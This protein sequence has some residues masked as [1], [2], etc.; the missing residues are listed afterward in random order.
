ML[1][2]LLCVQFALSIPLI[3]Y[4]QLQTVSRGARPLPFYYPRSIHTSYPYKI[5][6]TVTAIRNQPQRIETAHEHITRLLGQADWHFEQEFTSY[7]P[8]DKI[9]HMS[10]IK[11]HNGVNIINQRAQI[12]FRNGQIISVSS[13]EVNHF[14]KRDLHINGASARISVQEAINKAETELNCKKNNIPM[15]MSYVEIPAGLVYCYNFQVVNDKQK[16]WY[17]VSVDAET[18]TNY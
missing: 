18:S 3:K 17:Y 15:E 10:L 8:R 12:H 4:Y 9:Y 1:I 5:P 2:L 16:L 13:P 14:D 6:S 7:H 11:R